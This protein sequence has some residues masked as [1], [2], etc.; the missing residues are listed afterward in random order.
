[1]ETDHEAMIKVDY[2][3]YQATASLYDYTDYQA[4]AS[5]YGDMGYQA[6]ASLCD[7]GAIE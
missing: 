6:T 7:A 1:M 2:M 5:L 3:G 4:T